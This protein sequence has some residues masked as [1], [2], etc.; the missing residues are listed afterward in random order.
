MSFSP[1]DDRLSAITF[2]ADASSREKDY[3]VAGGF[4]VPGHRI[5]EIE[6]Y[7]AEL[8]A[9]HRIAE[10]HWADYRGGRK[11][12][13]Y[14]ALV[15]YAFELIA[16]H[17]AA[18]HIII[19]RFKGYRHKAKEGENRDTSINRMYYQLCLHRPARFYGRK[20]AIHIRFDA[21]N[22]SAD[23]CQMR[24]QLC[25]DA[26]KKYRT[27]PNCVR[28]IEPVS[29]HKVGIIQMA[30][31]ILG[32]AA[33]KRNQ[34]EHASPKGALADFV[35]KESGLRSWSESTPDRARYLTVWNHVGKGG[36]S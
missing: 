15:R 18:L 23:M 6:S 30:D 20:R 13:A 4:A 31:V 25:A 7:I 14:E 19:A 3:M 33:A 1:P 21:G 32:A 27:L 26:W 12:E 9:A 17:H 24:N 28:S 11:Q 8:R 2:F 5:V 16:S 34:V 36:P 35:L 10:F 29:S 22:D